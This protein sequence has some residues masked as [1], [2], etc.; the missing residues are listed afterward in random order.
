M[1]G[2]GGMETGDKSGGIDGGG[3]YRNAKGGTGRSGEGDRRAREGM[4]T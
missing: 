3:G 2:N 1:R 4:E